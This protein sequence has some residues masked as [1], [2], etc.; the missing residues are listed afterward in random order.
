MSSIVY[1][2]GAG[3]GDPGL[4]T[5]RGLR[6]LESARCRALR[7]SVHARL[8]AARQTET[9]RKLDVGLAAPRPLDR[10]AIC[11]LLAEKGT[12]KRGKTVARLKWGDPFVFGSGGPGGALSFT[13]KVCAS[14]WCRAFQSE[15]ERPPTPAFRSPTRVAATLSALSEGHEDDGQTRA[16]CELSSLA[17]CARRHDRV[18]RGATTA[19]ADRHRAA[20]ARTVAGR[21]GGRRLLGNASDAGDDRWERSTT[22]Q[23]DEA[24]TTD[25]PPA[26][27][28]VGRV[29]G[30][31]R[32]FAVVRLTS[33][34][35]QADPR[36]TA[37]RTGRR[38]FVVPA[39]AMG[40][41]S[42]RRLR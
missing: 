26:V 33:T 34:V 27:L 40:S 39:Q 17:I 5:A 4:I 29:A 7:P 15:S 16:D 37:A 28:I 14:R 32:A 41:R 9:R 22:S 2:I 36:H 12:A 20:G 23:T 13:S 21:H 18:L 3:P 11:Y 6:H 19:P 10:E 42:R 8:T 35:W 31:S 24:A 25:R 38:A 30:V 1:L